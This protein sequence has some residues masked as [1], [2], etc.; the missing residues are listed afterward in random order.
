MYA[1]EQGNEGGKCLLP[2]TV[3]GEPGIHSVRLILPFKH[4]YLFMRDIPI[5]YTI[6][7][8]DIKARRLTSRDIRGALRATT[9][10]SSPQLHAPQHPDLQ[11][12]NYSQ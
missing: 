6:L 10:P 8:S 4:S 2:V 3:S 11:R 9:R 1:S 12:P 5:F 7:K